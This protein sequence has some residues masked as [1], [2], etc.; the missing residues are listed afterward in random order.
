MDSKTKYKEIKEKVKN[1]D[2]GVGILD[3]EGWCLYKLVRHNNI[4]PVI[5][6]G[7]WK[8]RSTI[9]LAQ[10]CIDKLKEEDKSYI[11]YAVDPH[12]NTGTHKYESVGDTFEDFITNITEAEVSEI[13]TPIR[14]TSKKA[15]KEILWNL[16]VG[17]IGTGFV[18]IDGSHYY[19]DVRFDFDNWSKSLNL[20][21]SIALHDTIAYEGPSKV[22]I[23]E[24][25]NPEF[26]I[27][28]V[29]GQVV[30]FRRYT[31]TWWIP[32]W[33]YTMY[34]YW[35]VYSTLFKLA[36]KLP[37]SIKEKLK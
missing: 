21:G 28:R 8:G 2:P 14:M 4:G 25:F 13:I 37:S 9:W 27:I 24:I 22:V 31:R 11:V 16:E 36:T 30:V 33:N 10:A 26:R 17:K 7:S 35:I 19:E 29:C 23:E 32:I 1:I 15:L 18:F 5:E 34:L 3:K 20:G 6:I 12:S